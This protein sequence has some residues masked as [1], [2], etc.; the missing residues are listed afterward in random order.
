[1][2]KIKSEPVKIM[3]EV[4]ECEENMNYEKTHSV[5]LVRALGMIILTITL[6]SRQ[7]NLFNML[8][9]FAALGCIITTYASNDKCD[10]DS[11]S[12]REV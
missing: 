9:M 7:I 3:G 2:G 12:L 4:V 10:T 6:I 8:S 5:K 1:M 11:S